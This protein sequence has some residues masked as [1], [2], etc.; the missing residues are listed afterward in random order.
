MTSETVRPQL[1][2]K[3][4]LR[5]DRQTGRYLLLYPEM[6]LDL[7]HTATEIARLCTG[8]NTVENMV[9]RL[10]RMHD[11]ASVAEVARDVNR[12]LGALADRGL[13]QL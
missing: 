5:V 13:L 8:H 11:G 3:V 1:R 4:R 2:P 7:N 6:G 10:A 12:F 9:H